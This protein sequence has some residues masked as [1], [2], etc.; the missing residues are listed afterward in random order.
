MIQI[1]QIGSKWRIKIVEEEW[2][3]NNLVDMQLELSRI[4]ELKEKY[5]DIK[6]AR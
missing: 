1:K 4:L 2:E 3:F 6:N 5:G